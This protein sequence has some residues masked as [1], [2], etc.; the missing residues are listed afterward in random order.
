MDLGLGLL[1]DYP[2][3][4]N[5]YLAQVAEN[6]GFAEVWCAEET[7]TPG[8]RDLF[9]TATSIAL[10][11]QRIRIVI[12]NINPYTR[13]IAVVAATIGSLA[14]IAKDRVSVSYAAGG[15]N[16]MA[17]LGLTH[18]QPYSSI[19]DGV[20]ILQRLFRGETVNYTGVLGELHELRL[21]PVPRGKIPVLVGSRGPRILELAG[22][23]ADGVN[24][25]TSLSEIPRQLISVQK[26]LEKS[27][28][29]LSDIR[30]VY[31]TTGV[32]SI[33]EDPAQAREQARPMIA[34]RLYQEATRSYMKKLFS[35]EFMQQL[36]RGGLPGQQ[37]FLDKVAERHYQEYGIIGS[38]E[39]V[40]EKLA[41]LETLGISQF[42]WGLCFIDHPKKVLDL[43]G[44]KVL[45]RL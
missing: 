39:E 25:S 7:P 33:A 13:N 24:L 3:H 17:P 36:L 37:E 23:M 20:M 31:S 16:P 5:I 9:I 22:E 14:D 30:V 6:Y 32:V 8:F 28:R 40:A 15:I 2:Q 12:G 10:N 43:L 21:D 45:P 4:Q 42:T 35:R 26:G 11:T 1:G 29:E 27:G 19:R 41:H 38:P 18:R 44:Q 34:W